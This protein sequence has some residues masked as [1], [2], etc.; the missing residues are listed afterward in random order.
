MATAYLTETPSDIDILAA[1][2]EESADI[3][4]F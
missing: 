1:I 3:L 4:V 2:V